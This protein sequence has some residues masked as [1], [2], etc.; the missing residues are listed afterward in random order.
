MN[1]NTK[2]SSW[3]VLIVDDE[4]D[5]LFL[6]AELLGF[7][8]AE[9]ATA[10][11]GPACLALVDDFRP[12]LILMDIAMP[13]MDGWETHRRLRARPD[14]NHIPIVALTALAMPADAARAQEAGFDGY[15]TKPF[16]VK[17][18]AEELIEFVARFAASYPDQPS[19]PPAANG[20][21][22]HPQDTAGYPYATA[23]RK[24]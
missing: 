5:N 12:T 1:T 20:G 10:T 7:N 2:P 16:R 23:R 22:D 19:A 6:A 4:P 8:G 21:G 17:T 13:D 9:V 15:I 24:D 11:S 18:L 14:L 3:R